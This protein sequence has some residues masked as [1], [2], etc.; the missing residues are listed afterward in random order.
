MNPT[1]HYQATVQDLVF[2]ILNFVLKN[3]KTEVN[4]HNF[5]RIRYFRHEYGLLVWEMLLYF[6]LASH[7]DRASS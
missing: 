3:C 7:E 4:K 1:L 2:F 6:V 5:D